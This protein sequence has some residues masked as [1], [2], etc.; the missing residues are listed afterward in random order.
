MSANAV[1]SSSSSSSLDG[2]QAL[3]VQAERYS[4]PDLP[5]EI[6]SNVAEYISKFIR[7]EQ[8]NQDRHIKYA[9]DGAERYGNRYSGVY[10]FKFVNA[11]RSLT[12]TNLPRMDNNISAVIDG[13]V[14]YV[15][16]S[17]RLKNTDKVQVIIQDLDQ[18]LHI[19]TNFLEIGNRS[20]SEAAINVIVNSFQSVEAFN[21]H[22]TRIIVKYGRRMRGGGY[23]CENLSLSKFLAKKRC[24]MKITTRNGRNDC[25]YQC[26]AI[27]LTDNGQKL[28]QA[29]REVEGNV[30]RVLLGMEY[31]ESVSFSSFPTIENALGISIYVIDYV[32][33]QFTYKSK[34]EYDTK[35]FMLYTLT[36]DNATVGHFH[37]INPKSIGAMWEKRKFCFNCMT[38]YQDARHKCIKVCYGCS[39]ETCEGRF[40]TVD[41]FKKSCLTCNMTVFDDTCLY[42]HKCGK[43]RKCLDCEMSYTFNKNKAH[44]CNSF[45]CSNCKLVIPVKGVHECYVQK[46]K[47]SEKKRSTNYIFFDYECFI[48]NNNHN[49]A[50]I[51]A[52]KYESSEFYRFKTDDEFIDWLREQKKNTT[53]IS[54][55]GGRYDMHYVKRALI[56]RRIAT[57]DI[58]NGKTI[59]VSTVANLKLRFIDSRRFIPLPLRAFSNTFNVNELTKGYFP[60]R[61][62]TTQNKDYIGKMPALEWFDFDSLKDHENPLKSERKKALAW[63]EEHKNDT[64]NLYEMCMKYCESDVALLREGC[65]RYKTL[66]ENIT[67]DHIDPFENITIASTCMKIYRTF[68]MPEQTI[69]VLDTR[70]DI[71]FK[72]QLWLRYMI[73]QNNDEIVL[74]YEIMGRNVD[75]FSRQ[76][77]TVYLY[78]NCLDTG[79]N[80]CHSP[81]T[82]HPVLFRKTWELAHSAKKFNADLINGGYNIEMIKECVWDRDMEYNL[83]V[84]EAMKDADEQN[85]K[86]VIRRAFYG[87]R[88]EPLKMYYAC[89]DG[90]VIR[91]LD[92]TSLYPYCQYC[93]YRGIT[94]STM[95]D[96]KDFYYPSG[97]PTVIKHN[98]KDISEYFGFACVT[99]Q[100]PEDLYHPVLPELKNGKLVFD[101]TLKTGCW[102]TMELVKAVAMGYKILKIHEVQHFK[103]RTS[104]LFKEYV[105]TFLKIKQEAAGWKKL[106]C[107]T[108]DEKIAYIKRYKEVMGITLEYDNVQENPGLYYIAKLCLNSL[109]GKFG[110]RDK[111]SETQDIFEWEDFEK[112]TQCSETE[113]SGIFFH[114]NVARTVTYTKKSEFSSL[115]KSTNIAVAAF[116]TAYARLRL[117][118]VMEILGERVLYTDTDS[119]IFVDDVNN[120]VDIVCGEFLGDLTDELDG[121]VITEFVSTGPKSYAYKTKKGKY[122]TKIK[123]FTLNYEASQ[124]LN[125]E[126][127]KKIVCEDPKL[128]VTTPGLQFII[129]DDHT[130]RT[131]ENASKVFGLTFDKRKIN[132]ESGSAT[133]ID[134][135]PFKKQRIE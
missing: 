100:P 5:S 135:S 18:D 40:A 127:L 84:K 89:K 123:G 30:Y 102:S 7:N 124:L 128:K 27:A 47:T 58:S 10:M 101:L 16:T 36:V 24:I 46:L 12:L 104:N 54:H 99:V 15:I 45:E 31:K 130:I 103:K 53:C 96:V 91:Y 119:V 35:V 14:M 120:P 76:K 21:M 13:A 116:T 34:T 83:Q 105:R 131:K 98:F 133:C 79:C 125:F 4:Y 112:I 113:I 80:K 20:F 118:E 56:R 111:F 95:N 57:D 114:D 8:E 71:S 23:Y 117:Y 1:S 122:T 75:G 52:M 107:N 61:F 11:P 86:C 64:I 134:S 41:E 108:E 121:D 78:L 74:D 132:W 9:L 67:H 94:S 49:T 42:H 6:T 82:I 29:Q 87:G 129:A 72:K 38:G 69:A 97:H 19:G 55:N 90:E 17:K 2:Y 77:N 28:K 65:I 32:S 59:M 43:T 51:V 44:E 93:V 22:T 60:Y 25:F 37:F 81:F 39:K 66:F 70:E 115:P 26:L 3:R 109:W 33:L 68:Y 48:D 88:T 106:N 126:T 92:Y 63:Y 85:L 50:G 62:F 73:E 110:Q